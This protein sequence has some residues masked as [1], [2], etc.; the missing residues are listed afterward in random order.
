M[1]DFARA[2]AIALFFFVV[3]GVTEGLAIRALQPTELELDWVSDAV[4]SVVLGF[5]IYLWLLLR[6]TRLALLTRERADLVLQTELSMAEAM[7]RRLLP[8]SPP[9]LA[10]FECAAVLKPAGRIGGDLYDFVQP[11]PSV[12]LLLLADVSGKGISAAMALTLVHATFRNVVRDTHRPS[13]VASRMSAAFRDEWHGTP[14]VTAI[15]ARLDADRHTLTYTNAGHPPAV[16]V[17]RQS[18]RS[19]KEGGPPLGLLEDA[20]FNDE[21]IELERGDVCVLMTDGISESLGD[22]LEPARAAIAATIRETPGLPSSMCQALMALALRGPGPRGV[23]DWNDDRT[24]VVIAVPEPPITT[25]ATR[26]SHRRAPESERHSKE[27]PVCASR[28]SAADSRE[29]SSGP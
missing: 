21:Q 17:G 23:D 6:A 11:A 9:S 29:D 15:I 12:C 7:Q 22:A 16:L 4:L 2:A 20:R 5:A 13:L 10:G 24:V 14:Y 25:T 19:L 3:A 27:V 28:R 8:D 18:D 1:K 26:P